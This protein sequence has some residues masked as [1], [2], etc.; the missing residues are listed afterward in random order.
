MNDSSAA[1]NLDRLIG[2]LGDWRGKLIGRIGRLMR[3]ADPE[4]VLEWKWMGTPTWAHH[5]IVAIANPHKGKVKVTFAQGAKLPDPTKLF[6]AGL[7][8]RLWRA[9][10]LFET[11]T[12]NEP[13]FRH[14][15]LAAVALNRAQFIEKGAR[16]ARRHARTGRTKRSRA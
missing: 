12:L 15:V 4:M 2:E 16:A 11:S 1:E 7:G 5:G 10:D 13:A 14:L 9:I 3:Q 6:N 8:G